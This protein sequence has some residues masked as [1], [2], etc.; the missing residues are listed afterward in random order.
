MD[1]FVQSFFVL[2]NNKFVETPDQMEKLEEHAYN[3][4]KNTIEEQL[5]LQDN[6]VSFSYTDNID[7]LSRKD[8]VQFVSEWNDKRNS[9]E[10]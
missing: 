3:M 6:G 1:L 8:L 10:Q 9:N 7:A 4:Y 2:V 5:Y